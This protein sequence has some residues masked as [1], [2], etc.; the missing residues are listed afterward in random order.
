MIHH[1]SMRRLIRE[2]LESIDAYYPVTESIID[3]IQ[4]TFLNE[5]NTDTFFN[6]GYPLR[7]GLMRMSKE[8]VKDIICDVIRPNQTYASNIRNACLV[9]PSMDSIEDV[10]V[11]CSYNIALQVLLTYYWYVSELEEFPMGIEDVA[12][13][14]LTHYRMEHPNAVSHKNVI[15]NF[16]AYQSNTQ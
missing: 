5:S 7:H 11:A 9:D 15:D 1:S 14:Y 16:L 3:L 2:T 4:L 8:Q 6:D 13:A 10:F 12:S